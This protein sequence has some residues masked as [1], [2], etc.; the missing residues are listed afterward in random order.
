[1]DKKASFLAIKSGLSFHYGPKNPAGSGG[2]ELSQLT[3]FLPFFVFFGH[4]KKN[5]EV[6][7]S[8]S[9]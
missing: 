4:V 1:M 3:D 9:E 7:L 5:K 8:F 2:L 6:T